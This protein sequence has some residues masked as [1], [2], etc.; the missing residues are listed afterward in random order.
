MAKKLREQL[1]DF[2]HGKEILDI[3][4]VG[5]IDLDDKPVRFYSSLSHV[6]VKIR[7][8]RADNKYIEI[9]HTV[10]DFGEGLQFI[11]ALYVRLIDEIR[12]PDDYEDEPDMINC[13][14]SIEQEVLLFPDGRNVIDDIIFHGLIEKEDAIICGALEIVA[15][16]NLIFFDPINFDG[17]LIGGEA[18]K[19]D[20]IEKFKFQNDGKLPQM[21]SLFENLNG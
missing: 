9:E 7:I 21:V 20:W 6:C 11:Y 3:E 15:D 18:K 17:T 8:P 1:R 16:K 13:V 10:A 19:Q 5:F 12:F 4:R 2:I 14:S